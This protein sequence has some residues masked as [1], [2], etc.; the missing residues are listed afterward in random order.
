MVNFDIKKII[1]TIN[2]FSL[3]EGGS[4]NKEKVLKLIWLSDKL[5]LRKYGRTII[6]DN[7]IATKNGLFPVFT[8]KILDNMDNQYLDIIKYVI[9]IDENYCTSI[10]SLDQNCFSK[11]DLS[12]LETVYNYYGEFDYHMLNEISFGCS[13]W[14]QIENMLNYKTTINID[15]CNFFDI[16]FNEMFNQDN[17]TLDLSKEIFMESEEIKNLFK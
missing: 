12:V 15:F 7:Y 4:I 11:S 8:K 5:H 16:E 17:F 10:S 2:F 3:K 13:E 14:K 6:D 1:Q 9:S